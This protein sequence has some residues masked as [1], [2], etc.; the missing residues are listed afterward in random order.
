[1]LATLKATMRIMIRIIRI[2]MINNHK[3]KS[4]HVAC[5]VNLSSGN[6]F[7]GLVI[8]ISV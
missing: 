4:D 5:K 1:M 6:D 2:M 7:L 3:N 8:E